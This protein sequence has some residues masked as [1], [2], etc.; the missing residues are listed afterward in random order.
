MATETIDRFSCIRHCT[1]REGHKGCIYQSFCPSRVLP[2][3]IQEDMAE[4]KICKVCGKELDASEFYGTDRTC[5]KCRA[6]LNNKRR[7]E[8]KLEE[9][10]RAEAFRETLAKSI[11]NGVE[12]TERGVVVATYLEEAKIPV[13][14]RPNLSQV[15][16]ID[17]KREL[18]RR[19]WVVACKRT[20]VEE[21]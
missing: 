4:K 3:E 13:E 11:A 8:R 21:L 7:A 12:T 17:L 14:M 10:A 1:F 20:I 15:A 18:E 6:S 9:K 2:G 5:K 16:D 19:G